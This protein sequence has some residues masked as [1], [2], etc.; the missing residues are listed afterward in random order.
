MAN[1]A[2]AASAE[3]IERGNKVLETYGQA[4]GKKEDALIRIFDLAEK[5]AIKGTHPALESNLNA[6]DSTISTLIKQIN[7][8]VAGQDVQIQELGE[9][10]NAAIEEKNAA[11]ASAA[12]SQKEAE[13]KLAEAA[14]TQKEAAEQIKQTKDEAAK[15]IKEAIGQREAALRERD[16]ARTI[17]AEKTASND[18]LMKQMTTMQTDV[19]AHQALK[20]KYE[21]LKE[22]LTAAQLKIQMNELK[23]EKD[24]AEAVMNKE[25]EMQ[26]QLRTCDRENA[27]LQAK[28]EQLLE[29]I[30]QLRESNS[31]TIKSEE[32]KLRADR[33]EKK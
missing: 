8:I 5:E 7:G 6:I 20:V 29:E 12:Q 14:L 32:Q 30:A 19:E 26:E 13:Q 16:D 22:Q 28:I 3:T 11:I 31:Q 2:V 17:A 9:R 1:F 33:N 27:K 23:F 18:L 4:G 10:L 15:E 24:C 25:R 21:D